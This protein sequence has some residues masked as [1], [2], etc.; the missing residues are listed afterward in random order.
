MDAAVVG[1]TEADCVTAALN[2]LVPEGAVLYDAPQI[3]VMV[4]RFADE[5]HAMAGT[6]KLE[7]SDFEVLEG[8]RGRGYALTTPPEMALIAEVARG[9]GVVLD[10]VYTGKAWRGM[11]AWLGAAD[12]AAAARPVFVHTGGL[13]GLMAFGSEIV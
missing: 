7:E 9:D 10:P 12:P 1:A 2:V 13:F 4:T 3:K 11:L 6:P 5:A 8:F